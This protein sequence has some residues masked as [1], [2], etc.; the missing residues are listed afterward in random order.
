[1]PAPLRGIASARRRV[2]MTSLAV[3]LALAAA[4]AAQQPRITNGRLTAQPAASPLAAAFR[5]LVAA[6]PDVTWIGYFVPVADRE[7]VMCCFGSGN[8]WVSGSVVMSDGSPCCGACRLEQTSTGTAT[9]SSPPSSL[10][11][12]PAGGVVKLE[13][14][15]RV[16][17][18][19]R[20]ADRRVDRIRV[21]SEDC[22]LDAGGRAVQWL[23]N[24]RPADSVAL[25]ESFTA[26]DANDRT[27]VVD[28]AVTA[29]AL[30]G[31]PSADAS[32]E[33]L[34]ATSQPE[35]LRKKVMFWL[36]NVRGRRG[37]DTLR[38]VMREDPSVEVRK[39]A[40]FALSQSRVPETFDT[41]AAIARSD[42]EPR[43]RSEALFWLAQK[44]DARAAKVITDA[45][46]KDASAEVRK[47]AV[48]ALSQL[49]AD[50]GV[51]ALIQIAR[52]HGDAATRGEAI[53]WLGQKAGTKASAAITELIDQDPDTDVKKK[54]VFALSQ[55]PK[56]EG[57]PLL[58]K[59]ART[60][61]NPAVRKQAMFW[62]GQ[63]K[64]PRAIDFFAE[65][66]K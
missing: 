56:D 15:E 13:G 12:S 44:G 3:T 49:K 25:L 60:N 35:S 1:M 19:Y 33:R 64:D 57:V 32:L 50:A 34:I 61:T 46:E 38:R 24:V 16:A 21:F 14:S 2:M 66:L 36:G 8:N 17:V 10:G 41:L 7:R 5:S 54:A 47:K 11:G 55:L 6:Q 39:S 28:G 30:H 53:F 22:E 26:P 23:E 43:L 4:V 27:R 62:L 42:S 31:D 58:I 51:P 48:F 52:T 40:I 9:S 18:L 63:S 20:I 59:V 37:F 29:I 65:V 45:L